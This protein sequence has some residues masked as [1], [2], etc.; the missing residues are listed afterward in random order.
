MSEY[1]TENAPLTL[2]FKAQT[3][4]VVKSCQIMLNHVKLDHQNMTLGP[5]G[6]PLK[7]VSCPKQCHSSLCITTL[8]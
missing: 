6:D 7:I 2:E 5:D 4:T 3:V 8:E 1:C